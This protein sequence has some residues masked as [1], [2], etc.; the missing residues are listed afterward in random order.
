MEN[1]PSNFTN[2]NISSPDLAT[3][4]AADQAAGQ[5][6]NQANGTDSI[7]NGNLSYTILNSQERHCQGISDVIKLAHGSEITEKHIS[8][9]EEEHVLAQIEKHPTGHFVA[10]A[11][12][13]GKETVLATAITMRTHYSPDYE[14]QPWLEMIGSVEIPKHNPEG[15]WLYGVE[16]SVHPDYQGKGIGSALYSVRFDY[17]RQENLKG[18]YACGMLKGYDDY[19]NEYT[20]QEYGDL[21]IKGEIVDPTVSVQ[22]KN[23]FQPKAVVQSYEVD[24]DAGNAAMLIVW[25]SPDFDES[26]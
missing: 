12:I 1:H 15:E 8:F 2:S 18:M 3:D 13:D 21:V 7:G 4:Q 23:G 20:Q 22:I 26:T 19:R 11:T 5:A 17:V 6:K 24:Y 10:V 9:P 14:P 25:D 16:C